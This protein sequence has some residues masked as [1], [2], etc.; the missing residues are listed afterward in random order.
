M[1]AMSMPSLHA[2]PSLR[3]WLWPTSLTLLVLTLL[4]DASGL[5]RPTM[6]WF[7][8]AEGFPLRHQ[9]WLEHVL[10]DA[11]RHVATLAHLGLVAMVFWPVGP[12]RQLSRWERLSVAVGV[13]LGLL[14]VNWIKRH[15]LTSCPWDL[16][17]FGGVAHYVSHWAWGSVDGGGGNCFPG[18]HASA[19]LAFLGL[20][21]PWLASAQPQARLIG[22]RLLIG[23]I[24][25][26]LLLGLTQT[27]RG[28]HYPSHT[29]WTGLICWG[30]ALLNHEFFA[31]LAQWR[32]RR[33][34]SVPST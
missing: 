4:W 17:E 12:M 2:H 29:L 13:T 19:A 3:P 25:L 16:N 26:G 18:G 31:G 34:A 23:V 27:L 8:T 15:S 10:H 14:A 9:W 6:A 11:M 33:T 22:R 7:A 28:A 30:V 21:L 32:T 24:G 5:D 1:A 20:P